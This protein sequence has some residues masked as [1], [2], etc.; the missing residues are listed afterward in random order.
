MTPPADIISNKKS[1]MLFPRFK[2]KQI[3]PNKL[4]DCKRNLDIPHLE[5]VLY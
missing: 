1:N 4:C 5:I 2:I 3:I